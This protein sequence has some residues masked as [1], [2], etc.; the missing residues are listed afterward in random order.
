MVL[1]TLVSALAIGLPAL[2]DPNAALKEIND[3][4]T[5]E[6]TKAREAKT[7][8]DYNAIDAKVKSM[9]SKAIVGVKPGSIDPKEGYVWMQLFSMAEK[10]EDI[11][12]LCDQFMTS[13]PSDKE[14]F[15]AETTCML[16]YQAMG[17]YT[18]AV[19]TLKNLR[20]TTL[21]EVGQVVMNACYVFVEPVVQAQGIS[22]GIS[23]L[24]AVETKIPASGATDQ[25]KNQIASYVGLIATTKAELLADH[26]MKDEAL[27]V[28]TLAEGDSRM[29]TSGARGVKATKTRLLLI[30]APA[31]EV[32]SERGYGEYP[33][34]AGLKGKVVLLDFFA[35][36][37]GPCKAAFPD[38]RKF[39][40]EFKGQGLE[41][42]GVT[43]YYGYYGAE[44]NLDKDTEFGKMA[45]FQKEF[46]MNWPI[47]FDASDSFT[48]YG[49]TGI[50]TVAVVDRKGVCRMLHVGYSPESFA[51]FRK[52]VIDILNEK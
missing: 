4:R 33:G 36:W 31:P 49:I 10:Y 43:R 21:T 51:K 45:G 25:E 44:K 46:N 41:I 50:P 6:F 14:M 40:D 39:Y 24:N 52:E 27:K 18:E 7:T 20:P 35:H 3:Y 15:S 23:M 42:V 13:H 29:T 38:M 17:R 8:P 26:G 48:N 19:D 30:G 28:L 22:N 34:L 32:K 5:A 16:A 37:C 47:V 1:T 12:A 2:G 9:A 11:K